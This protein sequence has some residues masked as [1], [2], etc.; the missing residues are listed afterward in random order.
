MTRL[1]RGR[2]GEAS[3]RC[4]RV[5]LVILKRATPQKQRKCTHSNTNPF[6]QCIIHGNTSLSFLKINLKCHHP[7]ISEK[8]WDDQESKSWRRSIHTRVLSLF[9]SF[10]CSLDYQASSS[11][12]IIKCWLDCGRLSNLTWF[13]FS[14]FFEIK[15]TSI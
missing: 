4:E 11:L 2:T 10:W 6:H 12:F 5:F 15:L 8:L 13:S 9:V 1:R 7:S 14:F 3:P